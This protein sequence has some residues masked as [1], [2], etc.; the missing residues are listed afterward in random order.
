[1]SES[2][3]HVLIDELQRTDEDPILALRV[4]PEWI[5]LHGEAMADEVMNFIAN[6]K[7]PHGIRRDFNGA[8]NFLFHFNQ[9]AD[10]SDCREATAEQF[11]QAF[12]FSPRGVAYA[13]AKGSVGISSVPLVYGAVIHKAGVRQGDVQKYG[14]FYH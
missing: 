9:S 5:T 12:T 13:L 10:I 1:M 8:R 14:F 3:L 2:Q 7:M 4:N 11:D 6:F